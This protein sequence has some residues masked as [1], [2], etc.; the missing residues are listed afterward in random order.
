MDETKAESL[1]GAEKP[2]KDVELNS[3]STQQ[4]SNPQILDVSVQKRRYGQA[5]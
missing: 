2:P 3:P 4:S 1:V 5:L